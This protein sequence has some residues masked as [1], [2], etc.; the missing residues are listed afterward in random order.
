MYKKHFTD[1]LTTILQENLTENQAEDFAEKLAHECA[2]NEP[3]AVDK[4]TDVLAGIGLKMDHILHRAAAQ[5]AKELGQ[6]YV[7]RRPGAVKLI[8]KLLAKASVSVEALTAEALAEELDY[9][10]RIDRLVTIAEGRRNASLREIDRRRAVLGES[11]RRSVQEAEDREL[12]VIEA[13]PAKE[14]DAA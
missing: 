6:Q 10:E 8:H 4:V 13:T 2:L 14:E 11:L 1:E 9:I 12:E 5:K 7:R 3:A